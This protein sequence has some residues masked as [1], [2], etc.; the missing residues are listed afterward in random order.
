MVLH[1]HCVLWLDCYCYDTGSYAEHSNDPLMQVYEL[2]L[3]M[4]R[5]TTA[6]VFLGC[7]ALHQGQHLQAVDLVN[8]PSTG[9]IDM[10]A[11][12]TSAVLY[13]VVL[14]SVVSAA[15]AVPYIHSVAHILKQEIG[16]GIATTSAA[17][18]CLVLVDISMYILG[19]V[20]VSAIVRS[21]VCIQ[22]DAS[23][24]YWLLVLTTICSYSL[25]ACCSVSLQSLRAAWSVFAIVSA[26][27]LIFTGFLQRLGSLGGLWKVRLVCG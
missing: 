3:G 14:L 17:Y 11:Y 10:H 9:L 7:I 12:N 20:L 2:M 4:L 27:C 24:Y 22:G 16:A 6:A 1:V 15:F 18:A 13:A 8:S 21:M 5:F 25:A 19:C 26:V 23:A